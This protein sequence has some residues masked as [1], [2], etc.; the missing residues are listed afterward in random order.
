MSFPGFLSMRR[1]PRAALLAASLA[2]LLLAACGGGTSQIDPFDAERVIV[3]GDE[4]SVLTADGRKYA[5]NVR[6]DDNSL[7]CAAQPIW[8]QSVASVYG[9]VFAEC[10]PSNVASPQAF[11]RAQA[12]ARV[13]DLA[14]QID[15]QLA[16]TGFAGRTLVTVLVGANDVLDLYA[17]FPDLGRDALLT[18]ARDRGEQ[19]AAQ[20]NRLVE[21]GA[22]V[23]VS[24]V[25][26]IGLTPYAL[27]Q[28]AANT[29]TDRA[30]LLSALT[31][32]LN[33]GLR[34]DVLNDGRFVGLVL[35]DEMVQAMVKSPGSFALNNAKDAACS[36]ALP[37]CSNKTLVSGADAVSWLWADTLRMG[38]AAQSRL[39]SLAVSRVRNNP[40]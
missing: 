15:A 23:V 14:T 7:D 29:D 33:T 22:R 12:G 40:F 35:A 21:A 30:A 26:D 39:G 9:F 38:Y 2:A 10:N 31:T 34:V 4:S 3:F 24:T 11:M 28:K 6:K 25:P 32:A 19:L 8:V 37:D 20:V 27:A 5:V 1:R 36:A 17:Q 18:Q 13:A 16:G